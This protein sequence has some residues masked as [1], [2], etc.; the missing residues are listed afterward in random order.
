MLRKKKFEDE[1]QFYQN[2]KDDDKIRHHL[3]R[4]HVLSQ[5][6]VTKHLYV[7]WLMFAYAL[8]NMDLKETFGQLLRLFVTIPG[9]MMGRVPRGNI[10]WSTVGLT[11][12]MQVPE[13]LKSVLTE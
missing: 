6:S 12:V 11:E 4:A 13:D 1:L 7:H 9:H 3:G 2:S 10:G 5:N 8:K